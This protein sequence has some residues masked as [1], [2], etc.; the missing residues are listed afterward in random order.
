MLTIRR[1]RTVA[2]TGRAAAVLLLA[3][4][5]SLLLMSPSSSAPGEEDLP[6][7]T[8]VP[9][10]EGAVANDQAIAALTQTSTVR[11]SKTN[12][13][14]G[15]D[16]PMWGALYTF[17]YNTPTD[18]PV[19]YLQPC[20][21]NRPCIPN[22]FA[23]PACATD[24]LSTQSR[25][26]FFRH[27]LYPVSPLATGGADVGLLAKVPV[28]LSAFGS[29]PAEVTLTLR[30]PRVD[31]RVKPLNIYM[32]Q[33]NPSALSCDPD[34]V[35]PS[36]FDILAEGEVEISLSDLSVDGVDVPLGPSCRTVEPAELALWGE[37]SKGEYTA[38]DGGPLGAFDGL[39]PGSLGPLDNPYYPKE[40]QGRTIPASTGLTVPPFTGCGVGG[41]DLSPLVT[42][43]ASGPNNPIRATQGKVA[44]HSTLDGAKIDL[45]TVKDCFGDECPVIPAAPET[46][47][48][49]A[50][51]E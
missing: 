27:Q 23:Q 40:L 22:P 7:G 29:I 19:S 26:P 49:P 44:F 35:P 24:D 47:P 16:A 25:G 37:T 31:G 18:D 36:T 14:I 13:T 2:P 20:I 45:D 34:Y 21:R 12:I 4:A 48:L 9:G 33:I 5:L 15:P 10:I 42:S 39:H 1:R 3:G 43:M 38:R 8:L 11:A 46:P 50:G 32:W 28:K 30:T 51:D 6:V 41:E 17:M